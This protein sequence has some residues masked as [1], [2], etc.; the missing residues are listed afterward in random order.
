VCQTI[1]HV[2]VDTGSY[3]LRLIAPLNAALGLPALT[4]P[5]GG[6]VGECGQ[7]I[8]GY[9]WGGVFQADVKLAGEVAP[10]QS[11]QVIGTSPG[12]VATAPSACTSVGI[13][14][15]IV[16][17]LGANGILGVGIFREDCG[18]ACATSAISATYYACAGLTCTPSK[19]P[20]AQQVSNPVA[21]FATDNN[22]VVL[23]LPAVPAGGVASLTGTLTFGI[24]TQADNAIAGETRYAV[25]ANGNFVTVYKGIT[26][27]ASFLDSGSNGLFFNDASLPVCNVSKGFYCPVSLL[28][29]T[30][31]NRAFDGSASGIVSF[32]LIGADTLGASI[33]AASIGGTNGDGKRSGA[34]SFD[35]GLPFFF[36]RRVF[37]GFEGGQ[38]GAYWAY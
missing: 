37:V 14:L 21:A 24:G 16:P 6:S 30:A 8:S 29:L 3:G 23:T 31:T 25:D 20:L 19:M 17:A 35:W 38:G 11:I 10:A 4:A 12:G 26:M 1:D 13:N 2:M 28:S 34:N 9:T 7:F 27:T 32:T 36:G 22:G 5:A 33:N 15:G 18:S